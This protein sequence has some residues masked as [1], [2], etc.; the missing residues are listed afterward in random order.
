MTIHD[1]PQK[2][3]RWILILRITVVVLPVL[4]LIY[5]WLTFGSLIKVIVG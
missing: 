2:W 1:L 5:F 4:F 3:R